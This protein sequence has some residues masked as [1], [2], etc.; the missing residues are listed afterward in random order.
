[1]NAL[2]SN[3]ITPSHHTHV[4]SPLLSDNLQSPNAIPPRSSSTGFVT[5]G[6]SPRAAGKKPSSSVLRPISEQAWLSQGKTITASQEALGRATR[7]MTTPPRDGA[8]FDPLSTVPG[9]SRE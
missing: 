3:H 5:N 2:H 9:A 8:L 7:T 1:M 4:V 6:T